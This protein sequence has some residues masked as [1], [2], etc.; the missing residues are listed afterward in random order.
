MLLAADVGNTNVKLGIFDGDN[1]KFKL[2]FSTDENK[3]SDELAVEL[4][5]FLQI[6]NIDAKSI[7][8]AII[9]SVV[10][11]FT[12]NLRSA[13]MTVTGKKSL[14]IG[15]GLKTGLDIKIEHPETLGA[16]IVA[17]C[18]G[19]CEKYGGPLIMIFMGTATAIVY[20]DASNAYH[21]GAIAPGMGISLDA[22]TNHG[23][24]LSSVDM[25]AP[26]KVISSNTS[27]C[28]RS[29]IMFGTA[30]MLDGM[31]DMFNE[32]CKTERQ[33]VPDRRRNHRY[34]LRHETIILPPDAALPRLYGKRGRDRKRYGEDPQCRT[35]RSGRAVVQATARPPAGTP[36]GIGRDGDGDPKPEHHGDQRVQFLYPEPLYAG[37]RIETDLAG[38]YPR[39]RIENQRSLGR[40]LC[41]RYPL[42]RKIGF[43]F[44]FQR[45]GQD[46][47]AAR[48][49]RDALRS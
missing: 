8:G 25:K 2:R 43:R 38:L 33:T 23:A 15:P 46:R 26:K 12:Y 48:S 11:K 29:G 44:R 47:G 22:L 41:G 37:L 1:L 32:E 13:I 5:T 10:P 20:V 18:V 7:D 9:S 30:C 4:F 49:A 21:G 3:T 6:Y 27:D 42:F 40:A 35:E 34:I 17:G 28:I 19:A 24:L 45:G 36:V 14:L 16:D 31:V 39:D